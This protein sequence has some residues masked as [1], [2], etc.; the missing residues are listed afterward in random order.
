MTAFLFLPLPLAGGVDT[1]ALAKLAGAAGTVAAVPAGRAGEIAEA[2][3]SGPIRAWITCSPNPKSW[4]KF[5]AEATEPGILVAAGAIGTYAEPLDPLEGG[6][7]S[8]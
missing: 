3:L 4:P 6:E 8:V 5:M 2:D 7:M 1:A